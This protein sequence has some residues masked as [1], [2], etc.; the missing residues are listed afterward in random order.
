MTPE[1]RC[2]KTQPSCWVGSGTSQSDGKPSSPRLWGKMWKKTSKRRICIWNCYHLA[3]NLKATNKKIDLHLK[4]PISGL[5]PL[6]RIIRGQCYLVLLFIVRIRYPSIKS[7]KEVSRRFNNWIFKCGMCI[8]ILQCRICNPTI[9]NHVPHTWKQ[10][11][12]SFRFLMETITLSRPSS[13]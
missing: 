11:L 6:V 1:L 12:N 4:F 7:G 5:F 13:T 3:K 8:C 2:W 9:T 10:V